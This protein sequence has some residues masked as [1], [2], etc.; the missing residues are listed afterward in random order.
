MYALS[1]PYDLAAVGIATHAATAPLA[2]GDYLED[3]SA[4]GLGVGGH[5]FLADLDRADARAVV[6]YLRTL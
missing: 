2:D 3:A 4:P 5:P 1:A 6:E